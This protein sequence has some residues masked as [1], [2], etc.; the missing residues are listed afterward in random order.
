MTWQA[1][2]RATIR[3]D[4]RTL[5]GQAKSIGVQVIFPSVLPLGEKDEAKNRCIMQINFCLCGWYSHEGFGFYDNWTFFNDLRVSGR[6]GI[7]L[8]RRGKEVSRK[9]LATVVRWTLKLKDLAGGIQS[10]STHAISSGE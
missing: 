7:H 2:T 9:R 3:E 6:N 4:Y 1:G 8:S 5:R 10:G